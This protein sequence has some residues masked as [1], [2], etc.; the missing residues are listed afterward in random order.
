MIDDFL[1]DA[2]SQ[3]NEKRE[4][5]EN[6]R[7]GLTGYNRTLQIALDDGKIFHF[8]IT[9]GR[10][11]ELQNGPAENPEIV[12]E[13]DEKTLM[14]IWN[15]EMGAMKAMALKKIRVK[16]KLEDMIRIRKLF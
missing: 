13:T 10:A 6:L 14:A 2:I 15:K 7:S 8:V 3:F 1:K 12:I 5:D 11:G 9:D 16:A 4:T